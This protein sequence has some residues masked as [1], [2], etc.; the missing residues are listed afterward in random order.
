[1]NMAMQKLSSKQAKGAV[2]FEHPA[3]GKD[4]CGICEAFIAGSELCKK[5]A[6]HVETKDWCILFEHK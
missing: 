4:H 3:E 2:D 6:G 5:V 1:M